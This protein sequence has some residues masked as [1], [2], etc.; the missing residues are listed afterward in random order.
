MELILFV[1][2]RLDAADF[3]SL[4]RRDSCRFFVDAPVST[5]TAAAAAADLAADVDVVVDDFDDPEAPVDDEAAAWPDVVVDFFDAAVG[6]L[7]IDELDE[8]R[9]VD[10]TLSGDEFL[11]ALLAAADCCLSD[12]SSLLVVV[13]VC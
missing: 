1:L 12:I 3:F 13:V 9:L 7:R 2:V 10:L 8:T 11:F 5:S 6:S 4:S